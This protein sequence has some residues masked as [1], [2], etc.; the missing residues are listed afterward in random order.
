MEGSRTEPK[1]VP[2]AVF[3]RTSKATASGGLR[4]SEGRAQRTPSAGTVQGCRALCVCV[5]WVGGGGGKHDSDGRAW[6][7]PDRD[8]TLTTNCLGLSATPFS[9][10][11]SPPAGPRDRRGFPP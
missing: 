1:E 5:C 4:V 10:P 3:P 8:T 7:D 9:L 6:W 11:P 2:A